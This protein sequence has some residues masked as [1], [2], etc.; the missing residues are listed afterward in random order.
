MKVKIKVKIKTCP[1]DYWYHMHIGEEID[2]DVKEETDTAY[3]IETYQGKPFKWVDKKDC[4]I[5]EESAAEPVKENEKVIK[6]SLDTARKW[7]AESK[8]REISGVL[9]EF[10]LQAFT[11]E[12]LE[13][14]KGYTWYD[15]FSGNGICLSND[16]KCVF[17]TAEQALSAE[18]FAQLTHIVEKYNEG[19]YF[20]TQN[21]KTVHYYVTCISGGG[22][23]INTFTFGQLGFH[24]PFCD[25]DDAKLSMETNQSLWEQYWMIKK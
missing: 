16:K 20:K 25:F 4:E 2:I 6:L 7:Y 3:V 18:A 22:L 23:G 24:L 8:K 21:G 12:E 11:K 14:K 13:P 5:V 17:R 9:C 1:N 10:L 19:K 15:S